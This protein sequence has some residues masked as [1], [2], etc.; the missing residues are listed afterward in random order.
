MLLLTTSSGK[1]LGSELEP[2]AWLSALHKYLLN[3]L[4]CAWKGPL[5]T[6]LILLVDFK[7]SMIIFNQV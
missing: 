7:A 1:G 4:L 3:E 2:R 5:S 6:E